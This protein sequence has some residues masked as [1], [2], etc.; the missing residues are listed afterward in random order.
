MRLGAMGLSHAVPCPEGWQNRRLRFLTRINK[1]VRVDMPPETEVSFVPMA[2]IGEN[3][4][5][6]LDQ[7][8]PLDG[9]GDG[10][11]P[12]VDGDV[13][14]AKITPCFENGKG[15]FAEGLKNGIAFGTTELHVIRP[16]KDI[17]G[18]FLFYLSISELFRKLGEGAMYGA[19]GQKRVPEVYIKDFQTPLPPL[20]QQQKITAFLDRKTA[21]IDTLIAKKRRLLDL[22][23]EKRT[24]LITRA[25]TK[26]LNPDAPMK[27]SGIEWLGEIPAHWETKKMKFLFKGRGGGTPAT[28]N[29][30]YW[31]GDIPWVSPKDM[32]RQF[33][34]ETIDYITELAIDETSTNMVP[35]DS[36]L[37]VMRSGILRHTMPVGVAS[38]DVAINQDIKAMISIDRLSS[39]YLFWLIFAKKKSLLPL[40]FKIG[41]TVESLENRYIVNEALPVPPDDEQSQIISFALEVSENIK[42]IEESIKSAISK[43]EEYRS[44]LITNA[45]TGQIKVA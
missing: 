24:A 31:N 18:R 6:Q 15:A 14:V 37:I 29:K 35:C 8:K 10:Y 39:R 44:A 3:G 1:P 22:L 20:D 43:L 12:F 36:V 9:M 30:E 26:G 28:Q 34:S 5:I 23:D 27:D 19:G 16:A 41:C 11:T 38:R 13:V 25:V 45:V 42:K 7:V 40:W 32:K 17:D 2:A 21:E 33:I 4:G